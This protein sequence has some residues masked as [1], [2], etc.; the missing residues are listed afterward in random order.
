MS[1]IPL[2]ITELEGNLSLTS[3]GFRMSLQQRA[4]PKKICMTVQGQ[5]LS[6]DG[7]HPLLHSIESI[8][9]VLNP[10]LNIK[11]NPAYPNP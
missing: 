3:M 8:L 11:T 9:T 6:W 2:A 1:T 5:D 10:R 7:T 4:E